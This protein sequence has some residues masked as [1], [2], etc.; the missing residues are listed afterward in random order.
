[1]FRGPP[2]AAPEWRFLSRQEG[3]AHASLRTVSGQSCPS[4]RAFRAHWNDHRMDPSGGQLWRRRDRGPSG[5]EVLCCLIVHRTRSAPWVEVRCRIKSPSPLGASAGAGDESRTPRTQARPAG[6]FGRGRARHGES[7]LGP[8][9]GAAC[10]PDD[11]ARA[12]EPTRDRPT[13]TSGGWSRRVWRASRRLPPLAG[14]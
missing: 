12:G 9:V 11:D 6:G 2:R 14:S 8:R 5:A 4:L 3:P 7:Q 13:S 10:A 1:M